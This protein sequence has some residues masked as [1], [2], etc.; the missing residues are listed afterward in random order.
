MTRLLAAAIA[1]TLSCAAL[2]QAPVPA[3]MNAQATELATR[4]GR[5][6]SA[7]GLETIIKSRNVELLAAYGRALAN[8]N[9]GVDERVRGLVPMPADLEAVMVRYFADPVMGRR[10]PTLC[11][12]SLMRCRSPALFDLMLAAWRSSKPGDDTYN[13]GNAVVLYEAPEALA[14]L[15]AWLTAT[16]APKGEDQARVMRALGQQKYAPAI[17][18]LSALMA[19]APPGKPSVAAE[20]LNSI[21]TLASAEA[22]LARMEAIARVPSRPEI[23]NESKGLAAR[24]AQYPVEVKIP[25]A[26]VKAALPADTRDFAIQWLGTRKDPAAAPDVIVLLG[27]SA[28][29]SRSIEAIVA[30]DSPQV[31][32]EARAALDRY[33]R[34][35]KLQESTVRY[36]ASMLDAKI[37]DPAKHMAEKRAIQRDAD[38]GTHSQL[39]ERDLMEARKLKESNPQAYVT[40]VRE[41]IAAMEKLGADYPDSRPAKSAVDAA[42][43]QYTMDLAHYVRFRQKKPREALELYAAAQSGGEALA[44][45]AIAD[46]WQY[47]LADK[48]RALAEYRKMVAPMPT[49]DLVAQDRELALKAWGQRW[50]AAQIDYLATG[51]RFNGALLPEDVAVVMLAVSA[52][53]QYDYFG[54][55]TL[56]QRSQAARGNAGKPVDRAEFQRALS[57][58]PPSAFA[59]LASISF[60]SYLPDAQS[61]LAYF[62]RQ[63]PAGFATASYF[64]LL[65]QVGRGP[66]GP[67]Y[68]AMLA[69]GMS[70]GGSDPMREA[71]TRFFSERRIDVKALATKPADKRMS[72]PQAT[73]NLFIASLR[74]ADLATAMSC[75]TPQIQA[76]FRPLFSAMSPAEMRAAA[77]SFKGFKL[78][79]GFGQYQEAFVVRSD[80]NGGS[81]TFVN[82]GGAWRIDDM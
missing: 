17:P 55:S 78:S 8:S 79:G 39:L 47:D 69:P 62:A 82:S 72:S 7:E 48:Q 30:S 20:A 31:W 51:K 19:Q 44:A 57:A 27:E 64:A 41:Y 24:L 5:E 25:Y 34:E 36:A 6:R 40:A 65:E 43:R 59:L 13:L 53:G 45:F 28:T 35:G 61:I 23:V 46:T 80:G 1:I 26:R 50:L 14:Q 33:A 73:W 54:L 4:L 71:K 18:V 29:Y 37:A 77:D 2:A 60:A 10:L 22:V 42:R 32:K 3:N 74:K 70:T 67:A 68:A 81:V 52:G 9:K 75:L 56:A 16:D 49:G 38:F 15:T 58:L 11:A 63:D 66:E 12:A 76:K 21:Q